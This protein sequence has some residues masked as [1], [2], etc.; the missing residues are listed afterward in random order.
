M[1]MIFVRVRPKGHYGTGRNACVLKGWASRKMPTGKPDV[2]KLGRAVEDAM[3][4]VIYLDDSQI[5]EEHLSKVYGD[6]PGVDITITEIDDKISLTGK[7]WNNNTLYERKEE[8]HGK[9]RIDAETS[10]ER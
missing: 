1:N 5:V 4:G 10:L 8:D 3:N 9:E 6:T 7:A 2:L